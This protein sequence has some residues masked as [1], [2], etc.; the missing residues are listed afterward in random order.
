MIASLAMLQPATASI[1]A[2]I[3]AGYAAIVSTIIAAVQVAN[4]RR[5]RPKLN[6]AVR[7]NMAI[8]GDPAAEGMTFTMVKVSNAGRRPV[9]ITQIGELHLQNTGAF[10]GDIV[11][12]VPCELTE[13]QYALAKVDEKIVNHDRIRCFYVWDA[14]G[15][16]YRQNHARLHRRIYWAVRRSW[17]RL[18]D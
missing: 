12:P 17:S 3:T 7:R 13:G 2:L 1:I 4:F 18:V 15:R 16:L 10:Y 5:D 14:T 11:P 9:T 6:I 8:A